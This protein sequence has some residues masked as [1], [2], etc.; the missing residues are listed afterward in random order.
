MNDYIK[1]NFVILTLALNYLFEK[2]KFED[3]VEN[4]KYASP[5][6]PIDLK[7]YLPLL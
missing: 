7:L 6:C 3:I 2:D 1:P 5:S 4:L